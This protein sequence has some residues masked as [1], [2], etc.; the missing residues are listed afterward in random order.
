MEGWDDV[1]DDDDDGD[2]GTYPR[3]EGWGRGWSVGRC[4]RRGT[5]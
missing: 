4:V 5:C 3:V 1:D 2:Y